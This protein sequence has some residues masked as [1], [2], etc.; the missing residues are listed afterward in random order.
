[1]RTRKR[2]KKIGTGASGKLPEASVKLQEASQKDFFFFK[3]SEAAPRDPHPPENP[4]T[5]LKRIFGHG[6]LGG[7]VLQD[8]DSK[9]IWAFRSPNTGHGAI[10]KGVKA[11]PKVRASR[12]QHHRR[13]AAWG[14]MPKSHPRL[15]HASCACSPACSLPGMRRAR[16]LPFGVLE[17]WAACFPVLLPCCSRV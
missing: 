5:I 8:S 15:I 4:K 7:A 10:V 6:L 16:R 17:A 2:K 9:C 3:K 11:K 12:L 14:V 1:V 13:C